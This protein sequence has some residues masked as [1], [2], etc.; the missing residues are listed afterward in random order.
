[1]AVSVTPWSVAPVAVPGPQGEANVPNFFA[2]PAVGDVAPT[3]PAA[4]VFDDEEPPRLLLQAAATRTT[5]KSTAKTGFLLIPFT[6][7]IPG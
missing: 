3:P 7:P 6:L 1:M 2:V 4:V 5:P